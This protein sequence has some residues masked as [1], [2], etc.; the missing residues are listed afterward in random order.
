MITRSPQTQT[1]SGSRSQAQSK[2]KSNA[3]AQKP[4]LLRRSHSAPPAG[5]PAEEPRERE[6][7]EEAAPRSYQPHSDPE[8]VRTAEDV[9]RDSD[10]TSADEGA[11][12][13][14]EVATHRE[15]RSLGGM[16]EDVVTRRLYP[17]DQLD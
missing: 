5:M 9:E 1:S 15:G 11:N 12:D 13:S 6:R 8:M 3:Q 7:E 16:T 2:A 4:A 17:L 14:V 10:E